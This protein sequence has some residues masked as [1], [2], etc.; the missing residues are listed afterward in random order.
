[1]IPL[2]SDNCLVLSWLTLA[3]VEQ[4]ITS[5]LMALQYGI[6]IW[7][8]CFFVL[9]QYTCAT[10]KQFSQTCDITITPGNLHQPTV[11]SLATYVLTAIAPPRTSQY[12]L[13]TRCQVGVSKI[14]RLWPFKVKQGH[15]PLYQSKVHTYMNF[16]QWLTV[17]WD[18][19]FILCSFVTT[20][21]RHN[22]DSSRTLRCVKKSK[23][24][25]ANEIVANNII[26]LHTYTR[27]ILLL[28]SA[29]YRS[30]ILT[31]L[32]NRTKPFKTLFMS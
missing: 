23:F 25:Y 26:R 1:M 18:M 13:F 7:T 32:I 3:E 8:E 2:F 27:S 12:L 20:Y 29:I 22:S 11:A 6:I 4:P 15:Q 14:Y 5:I 9:S 24:F 10:D 30:S 21:R 17:T 28:S 31:T 16:Y 19:S